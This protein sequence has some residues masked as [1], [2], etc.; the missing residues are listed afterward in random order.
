MSRVPLLDQWKPLLPLLLP[1]LLL[2]LLMI[3]CLMFKPKQPVVKVESA[4]ATATTTAAEFEP[5]EL[6]SWEGIQNLWSPQPALVIGLGTAGWQVLTNLKKTLSDAGL[7]IPSE[8]VRLL[9]IIAGEQEKLI[10]DDFAGIALTRT[11]T[12]PSEKREIIEWRDPLQRLIDDA[13]NDAAA[14][15]WVDTRYLSNFTQSVSNPRLGF[16]GI[17]LLGRLALL[18][19][20]RGAKANTGVSVWDTLREASQEVKDENVLTVILITDLADDVGSGAALDI[21][22]LVKRLRDESDLGISTVRVI[23]HAVTARVS[24]VRAVDEGIRA[25]NTA[26]AL[27]EIE[28]FQLA[29][30]APFPMNYGKTADQPTPYDGVSSG[31]LFD[32]LYIH[33]SP[34]MVSPQ[35]S[36]YPLVSDAIALW[37]DEASAKGNLAGWRDSILS[38]MRDAQIKDQQ[39]MLGAV[40]LFQYR[41]PFAD[42]LDTITATFAYDVI[43]RLLMGNRDDLPRLVPNPQ[44]FVAESFVAGTRPLRTPRELA[45]AFLLEL[46]GSANWTEQWRRTWQSLPG[47]DTALLKQAL[48]K[49]KVDTAHDDQIFKNWL[50]SVTL[51]LLNGRKGGEDTEDA[52]AKRGAKLGLALD[53]LKNVGDENSGLLS[54]YANRVDQVAPEHDA[55]ASLR[56]FAA[57]TRALRADLLETGEGLGLEGKSDSLHRRLDNRKK[58]IARLSKNSLELKSRRY[59]TEARDKNNQTRPLADIWYGQY[60]LDHLREAIQQMH[61]MLNDAGKLVLS[62]RIAEKDDERERSKDI[63]FDPQNVEE[64]EAALIEIGQ[65]FARN[66]RA[67]ELLAKI[68]AVS[69]LH[70]DN[71]QET[72]RI[73]KEQL[74]P[75]IR[76]SGEAPRK[77]AS[78]VISSSESLGEV[79]QRLIA[80]LRR[81]IRD[82]DLI[83]ELRTD[84]PFT[85]TLAQTV[86]GIPKEA[87]STLVTDENRYAGEVYAQ[88]NARPAS[89]FDAEVHAVSYERRLVEIDQAPHIFNPIVVTA[90]AKRTQTEVYL[91]AAAALTQTNGTFNEL[92][93][94]RN[95]VIFNSRE[96][97]ELVLLAVDKAPLFSP[98]LDGLLEFGRRVDEATAQ[99]IFERYS[100]NDGLTD[101]IDAWELD[102]ASGKLWREKFAVGDDPALDDLVAITRLLIRAVLKPE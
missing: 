75:Q 61:W 43:Q 9:G 97:G 42:L 98:F 7:G 30:A 67:N 36:N 81:G 3:A 90:L 18:N 50:Y 15:Q 38:V 56:A 85:L 19:N 101:A 17:R 11:P 47:Q 44:D 23:T 63:L 28:R 96:T 72:V 53:F 92:R 95:R 84:D 49:L 29:G 45:Q 20:L 33:D 26:A 35:L 16:Q 6:R 88:N 69:I 27:R 1:F 100:N 62:L 99:A 76:T 2:L 12:N 82:Q 41:L 86:D 40:G 65:Y 25:M 58:Q 5:M 55:S 8:K 77:T 87:V 48:D 59:I 52:V 57:I 83:K 24:G 74:T 10:T 64:F 4:T 79:G 13:P 34:G 93:V 89:V 80:E 60:L 70:P 37:L 73:L 22:Y 54:L 91:L 46:L 32:E 78:Y 68:L 102:S 51:V 94:E 31:V 39:V 71:L 21:G 14:R 66:V